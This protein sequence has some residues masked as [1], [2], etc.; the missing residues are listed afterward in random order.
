[1]R[2]DTDETRCPTNICSVNSEREAIG[3]VEKAMCDKTTQE[4]RR[5]RGIRD[6][7]KLIE[8]SD[9]RADRDGDA[10]GELNSSCRHWKDD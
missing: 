10:D 8:R 7:A 2:N 5:C 9:S 4:K 3:R 6:R 1:M